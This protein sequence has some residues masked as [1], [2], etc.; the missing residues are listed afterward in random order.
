MVMSSS[1]AWWKDVV[2]KQS[3]KILDGM[4]QP[5][6]L[7]SGLLLTDLL[8]SRWGFIRMNKKDKAGNTFLRKLRQ[9]WGLLWSSQVGGNTMPK[10]VALQTYPQIV[11]ERSGMVCATI[12]GGIPLFSD[13]LDY[14]VTLAL[15]YNPNRSSN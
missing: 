12:E 3:G 10:K 4:E 7:L 1:H 15:L 14:W 9:K 6:P 5:V 8:S 2:R 11:V 13:V